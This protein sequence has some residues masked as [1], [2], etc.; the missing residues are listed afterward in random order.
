MGSCKL[1]LPWLIWQCYG[2][3]VHEVVTMYFLRYHYWLLNITRDWKH[4]LQIAACQARLLWRE[5]CVSDQCRAR[6]KPASSSLM[7][8]K[9]GNLT[10]CKM[11]MCWSI[12]IISCALMAPQTM[13]FP[14]PCFTVLRVQLSCSASPGLLRTYTAPS[15]PNHI[16]FGLIS[17]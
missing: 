1:V 16:K 7:S 3:S 15:E 6:T 17:P 8:C 11:P 13:T 5:L 4:F 2:L 9:E 14:P 10:F 12:S